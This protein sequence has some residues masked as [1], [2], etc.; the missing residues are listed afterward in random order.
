MTP[1]R[2]IRGLRSLIAAVRQETAGNAVVELALVL[3]IL[4]AIV[5]GTFNYGIMGYQMSGLIGAVRAG[6]EYAAGY[7]SSTNLNVSTSTMGTGSSTVVNGF[8]TMPTTTVTP[9]SL[10]CKCSDGS[11]A[12][13]CLP[14]TSTGSSTPCGNGLFLR[15]WVNVSAT[16]SQPWFSIAGFSFSSPLSASAKLRAY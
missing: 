5:A 7:L 16:Q 2:I 14:F 8:T 6:A 12:T 9:A 10:T 13:T 4:L 1:R 3:P 11:D 15:T